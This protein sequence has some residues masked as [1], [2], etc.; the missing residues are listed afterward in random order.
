M[1]DLTLDRTPDTGTDTGTGP[2]AGTGPGESTTAAKAKRLRIFLVI[3]P[4]SAAN[5]VER[6][7][8][9]KGLKL[10][11]RRIESLVSMGLVSMG[12]SSERPSFTSPIPSAQVRRNYA[13]GWGKSD[14]RKPIR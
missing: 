7:R 8:R 10:G 2:A 9:T 13:I 6:Q 3:D 12:L 1:V 4:T 11:F 14:G 5:L